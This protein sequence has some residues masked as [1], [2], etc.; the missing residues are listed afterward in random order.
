MKES[1]GW[2]EHREQA[3]NL[4][5]EQKFD[6]ALTIYEQALEKADADGRLKLRQ[7]IIDCHL[8]VGH[9]HE[10]RQM[11]LSLMQDAASQGNRYV[12]AETKFA[13]GEQ[14]CQAGD[15]ATGYPYM[16]EAVRLM[17]SCK[18]SDA[19]YT[20]TFYHYRLMK[21]AAEDEDWPRVLS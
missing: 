10:A 7:D 8:A 9:D 19:P 2:E 21:R 16:H 12:E 17:S 11:M 3:N 13:L 20:L 1:A 18:D 5:N 6:E 4:Y 14:L 15:K